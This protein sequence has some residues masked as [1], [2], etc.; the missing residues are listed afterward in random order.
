[1]R[2][3]QIFQHPA[4]RSKKGDKSESLKREIILAF[5]SVTLEVLGLGFLKGGDLNG[6]L[7]KDHFLR[8]RTGGADRGTFEGQQVEEEKNLRRRARRTWFSVAKNSKREETRG[9]REGLP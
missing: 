5:L 4:R 3:N 6:R 7:D 1:V 9:V 8:H 2:S